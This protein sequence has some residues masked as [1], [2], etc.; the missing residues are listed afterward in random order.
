MH[1]CMFIYRHDGV[2]LNKK[3]GLT[4]TWNIMYEFQAFYWIIHKS[5]LFMIPFIWYIFKKAKMFQIVKADEYYGN[6]GE[7]WI[8]A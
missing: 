3:K 4:D 5:I 7:G 6:E 8:G 1:V 2:L